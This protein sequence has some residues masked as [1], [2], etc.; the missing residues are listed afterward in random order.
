MLLR[1]QGEP[2]RRHHGPGPHGFSGGSVCHATAPPV[3]QLEMNRESTAMAPSS[4]A[5]SM[6]AR[7]ASAPV[8]SCSTGGPFSSAREM[9]PPASRAEQ[10][11]RARG[12]SEP[13]PEPVPTCS[14]PAT[15]ASCSTPALPAG[16]GSRPS[17]AHRPVADPETPITLTVLERFTVPA[18]LPPGMPCPRPCI[19]PA[20][21]R[22]CGRTDNP[23]KRRPHRSHACS[24][25]RARGW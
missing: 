24:A 25:C 14:M 18:M 6:P 11:I 21:N 9:G 4:S 5:S 1:C 13:Q 17:I 20:C 23:R 22:V 16:R 3:L 15:S 7:P 2:L 8:G 10:R 12:S 19:N